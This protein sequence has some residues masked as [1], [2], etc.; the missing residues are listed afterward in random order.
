MLGCFLGQEELGQRNKVHHLIKSVHNGENDCVASG[1]RETCDKVN[2][3]LGHL[4]TGRGQ[5][6]PAEGT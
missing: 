2:R 6:W 4:G 3:D 1:P 5:R